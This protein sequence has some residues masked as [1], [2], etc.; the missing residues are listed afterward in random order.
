MIKFCLGFCKKY[1]HSRLDGCRLLPYGVFAV[2]GR[3]SRAW[4]EFP[5]ALS[6]MTG[7]APCAPWT[8]NTPYGS[9]RHPSSRKGTCRQYVRLPWGVGSSALAMLQVLI[10][11]TVARCSRP[12]SDGSTKTIS[13]G[14]HG[15]ETVGRMVPA[16]RQDCTILGRP[17]RREAQRDESP[18]RLDRVLLPRTTATLTLPIAL[19]LT[20]PGQRPG[21]PLVELQLPGR[22]KLSCA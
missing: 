6:C 8:A 4:R 12:C 17:R 22:H 13:K 20:M 11:S 15:G 7:G 16:R 18:G 1:D 3:V 5:F 21:P 10:D 14:E 9:S 2:H 19:C